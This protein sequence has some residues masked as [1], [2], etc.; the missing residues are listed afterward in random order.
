MKTGN[1]KLHCP[2]CNSKELR[3]KGFIKPK[4]N[5]VPIRQ[6][7]CFDCKARFTANSRKSTKRQRRPELN[8][9]IYA[10]YCEGNTL[11]G[12]ARLLG[13]EYNTVV[14][15]FKFI[16]HIARVEHLKA[17]KQG[18]FETTFVQIDE[19]ETF[20]KSLENP[21]GIELA[22]RP[23]T[24]EVISA[25]VCRIPVKA[26]TVSPQV[27]FEA[28]EKSNRENIQNEMCFEIDKVL[29]S[30]GT[31]LG[32]GSIP[33]TVR[34]IFKDKD[35]QS[36][37][38]LSAKDSRLWAINHI[39]AKFRH[40]ISRLHRK[41]WANTQKLERLQMHLDIFIACQNKYKLDI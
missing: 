14:S 36:E 3:K 26:Q 19:M 25:R 1:I 22:I 41:T 38:C 34:Q 27:K 15:K 37:S 32:D 20:E 39:C 4:K 16:A 21:L 6:Y 5:Q 13:C 29:K 28:K 9:K 18:T 35:I 23:K 24:L 17:L 8:K 7:Y 33:R 11:R 2:K 10:L 40:R 31:I 30:K 12:M